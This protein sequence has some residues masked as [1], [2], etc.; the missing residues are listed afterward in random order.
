MLNP[1]QRIRNTTREAFWWHSEKNMTVYPPQSLSKPCLHVY[2][3]RMRNCLFSLFTYLIIKLDLYRTC[4]IRVWT[5]M[6]LMTPLWDV[7][8]VASSHPH[9]RYRSE[10]VWDA[11]LTEMVPKRALLEHVRGDIFKEYLSQFEKGNSQLNLRA[12]QRKCST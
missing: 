9:F 5:R 4:W 6:E 2:L 12:N 3:Y 10:P 8:T 7:L 11:N 1:D